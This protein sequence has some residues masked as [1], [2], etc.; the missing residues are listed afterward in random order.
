MRDGFGYRSSEA[1]ASCEASYLVDLCCCF[2]LPEDVCYFASFKRSA[3]ACVY[4]VRLTKSLS[5]AARQHP[6]LPKEK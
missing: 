4:V 1:S 2:T 5:G 6:L 3:A